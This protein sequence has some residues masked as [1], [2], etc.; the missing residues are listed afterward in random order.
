MRST[1]RLRSVSRPSIYQFAGGDE[2]FLALAAAHHERCLEDPVLNHPFSHPGEPDHVERLARYW[3]EVFGGPPRYSESYGGH[4]GCW[5]STRGKAPRK[6]WAPASSRA[7]CKPRMTRPCPTTLPCVR[8]FAPTWSGPS[9]TC[10]GTHR[11]TP[12]FPLVHRRLIGRGAGSYALTLAR[13]VARHPP[14]GQVVPWGARVAP[15]ASGGFQ[16]GALGRVH[17]QPRCA[18]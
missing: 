1:T 2:A 5:Q 4:S 12:L 16:H 18:R 10:S 15:H 13:A 11:A 8:A 9:E 3:A 6:S 14:S 7:S 17:C